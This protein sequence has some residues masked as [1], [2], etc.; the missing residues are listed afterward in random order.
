VEIRLDDNGDVMKSSSDTPVDTLRVYG[1]LSLLEMAPVLLAAQV[2]AGKTRLEHG[3]VMSLWGE[4]SDLASLDSAGQSDIALNSETQALRASIAHPDLRFIFTVAECPY[5]IVARRS[6]GITKLA[7]LRGKRVGTQLESSAAYFLET[8]LRTVGLTGAD[9]VSVPFMAH[10]ERPIS[11]LPRALG[12]GEIDAVALWEPQV[13]RARL[14]IA[15]DA[16]E[17]RDAAVYTEKFN[18]C[19]TAANLADPGM[20]ERIVGFVRALIEAARQLRNEPRLGWELVAKAANL[21]IET[22]SSA[23]PYLNY[24]GTLASDLLDVFEKQEVWIA[25]IQGR[26]PRTRDALSKLIDDSVLRE[27]LATAP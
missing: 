22:V 6:S 11:L 14:A 7:D 19:T 21:D 27:A 8:M 12:S 9:I 3:S 23:W 16:I 24:P 5:R 20:R 4:S 1:N 18:L 17:F 25:E 13:Q 10:T 2:H 15:E 26:P